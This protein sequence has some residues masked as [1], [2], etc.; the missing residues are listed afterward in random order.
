MLERRF[1]TKLIHKLKDR[2]PGCVVIKNDAGYIQ[3]IPDL[4]VLYNDKWAMLECKKT[5]YS[6]VQPNQ[7]HYVKKF[8]EMSFATFISPETEEE[9][10]NEMESLFEPR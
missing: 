4:L 2:F 1:Q 10:L 9:V 5:T 6:H 3:G 7:Q 8:D